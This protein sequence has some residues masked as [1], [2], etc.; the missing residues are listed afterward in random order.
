MVKTEITKQPDGLVHATIVGKIDE[1]FDGKDILAAAAS[2]KT[3]VLKLDG[4]RSISSLG[5]RALETFMRS[6][7]TGGRQVMLDEISA[8]VANQF[9]MIPNLLAGAKVRSARLPF[10][11]TSCGTETVHAVPYEAGAAAAHAPS[12]PSC[13]AKMEFD[14]FSEEY[15]PHS[16]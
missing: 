9:S 10:V 16:R 6:I 5:T 1:H 7:I 15:L 12:C 13:K 8:A 2:A 14:G 3:V 11:C 4:V